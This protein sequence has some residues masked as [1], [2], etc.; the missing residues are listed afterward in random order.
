MTRKSEMKGKCRD[1]LGAFYKEGSLRI[2]TTICNNEGAPD[3]GHLVDS[4]HG[5][6]EFVS[7]VEYRKHYGIPG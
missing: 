3:F 2:G 5:C 7:L 4:D 6:A 1:C